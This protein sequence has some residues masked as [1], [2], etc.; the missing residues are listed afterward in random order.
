[1]NIN[2]IPLIISLIAGL[3]TMIGTLFIWIKPQ[4]INSFIGT[5]L[6]FSATIMILISITEL[7]PEG[8]FYLKY[9]YSL[10][11][12]ILSLILMIFIA[13]NINALINKKIKKSALKK[14]SLYRVG[15]LSMI[16]LIIHNLPEGLLTYISSSLDIK[17]GLKLAIAIMLHNIPEGIIIAVPIYYST[18]SKKR[19]VLTT[20][21]SGLSEPLG[22][23]L[24]ALLLKDY[25]TKTIVSIILLFVASIMVSIS[26]NDIFEETN[27]Y[28][29]KS[30]IIGVVLGII[31]AIIL[32]LIF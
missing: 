32:K 6:S 26:I 15:I 27:K 7:I 18:L 21:F 23:I 19:G 5:S 14:D 11:Y 3:S 31:L 12:A 22:A 1:M 20:L 17:L 9:K 30:L 8:F 29:K 16:A 4:N 25:L 28:S 2:I 13:N 24:A 10:I